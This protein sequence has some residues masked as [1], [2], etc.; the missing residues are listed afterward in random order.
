MCWLVAV[1]RTSG[2]ELDALSIDSSVSVGQ[3]FAFECI[4]FGLYFAVN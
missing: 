3:G 2:D 4:G 1:S